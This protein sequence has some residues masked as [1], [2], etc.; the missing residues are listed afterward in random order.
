MMASPAGDATIARLID[1][2][3]EVADGLGEVARAGA[4]SGADLSFVSDGDECAPARIARHYLLA[5]RRRER[6]F[7]E[8]LFADPA[9]DIL[10]DLFACEAEGRRLSVSDACLAANVPPTTALRWLAQL[11]ARGL[12]ERQPDPADGRRVF[13]T[14]RTPARDAVLEWLRATFK[15][16]SR[17]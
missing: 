9:W 3:R 12:V 1:L 16:P 15:V 13:V 4:G 2:A 14:L 6:L 11:E 17:A 8:G 10:L 7:P 5:R